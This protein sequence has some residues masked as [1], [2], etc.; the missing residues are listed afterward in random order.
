MFRL[1]T[2]TQVTKLILK[3][4]VKHLMVQNNYNYSFF[5]YHFDVPTGADYL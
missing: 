3:I 5:V 1:L 4:K 2:A